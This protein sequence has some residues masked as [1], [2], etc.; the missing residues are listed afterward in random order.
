MRAQRRPRP[1]TVACARL[2][3]EHCLF[4][5]WV[6]RKSSPPD[7]GAAKRAAAKRAAD[8]AGVTDALR[9]AWRAD[10]FVAAAWRADEF[11]AAAV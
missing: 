11:V 10:E 1:W 3:R 8:A 2:G 4:D 9:A 5:S 6:F 7:D